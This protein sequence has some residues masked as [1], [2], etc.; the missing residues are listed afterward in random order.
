MSGVIV[1]TRRLYSGWEIVSSCI[2]KSGSETSS[3]WMPSCHRAVVLL[4]LLLLLLLYLIKRAGPVLRYL[5]HL[6][7][8]H[9]EGCG[10]DSIPNG[11]GIFGHCMGSSSTLHREEFG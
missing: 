5:R 3:R 7:Y 8:T 6:I 10:V 1:N 11:G 2:L 4:L 9:T